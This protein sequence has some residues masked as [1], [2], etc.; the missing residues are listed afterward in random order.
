MSLIDRVIPRISVL[1]A[2]TYHLHR[3]IK[4]ENPM[5]RI[6]Y[7]NIINELYDDVRH[8][9]YTWSYVS[10]TIVAKHCLSLANKKQNMM[11][12]FNDNIVII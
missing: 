11:T 3:C 9:C 2:T 1:Y 7:L 10:P 12:K 6:K 5:Q 4:L 8:R